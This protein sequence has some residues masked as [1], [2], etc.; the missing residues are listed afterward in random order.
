MKKQCFH[1]CVSPTSLQGPAADPSCEEK[2]RRALPRVLQPSS[3][4]DDGPWRALGETRAHVR[5]ITYE[6]QLLAWGVWQQGVMKGGI[7][8]FFL[9]RN[10]I[11]TENVVK[12][13]QKFSSLCCLQ[14]LHVA[15]SPEKEEEEVDRILIFFA[16]F[17][18]LF[19]I[20]IQLVCEQM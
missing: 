4:P 5:L 2:A 1:A 16:A 19:D 10:Q 17:L 7:P 14:S 3:G 11:N 12:L 8:G 15:G 20:V 18:I 13:K 9:L 6:V